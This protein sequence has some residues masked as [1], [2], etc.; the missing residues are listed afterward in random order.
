MFGPKGRLWESQEQHLQATRSWQE[1]LDEAEGA[2]LRP[3]SRLSEA[4]PEVQAA[5]AEMGYDEA[6]EALTHQYRVFARATELLALSARRL[7][8]T[9]PE[10]KAL[11]GRAGHVRQ[12]L[13][14]CRPRMRPFGPKCI[15]D[16]HVCAKS[17]ACIHALQG[18]HGHIH[19][20][21]YIY[22]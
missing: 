2:L 22:I 18:V 3:A 17:I 21:I 4:L 20:C 8:A 14:P 1:C 13:R 5:A 15:N 9:D 16:P 12:V 19:T 11:L 10:G 7:S 6:S